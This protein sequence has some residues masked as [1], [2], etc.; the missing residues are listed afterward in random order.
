MVLFSL[1]IA[2]LIERTRQGPANWEVQPFAQ[3]WK[4]G[5]NRLNLSQEW[6]H[7]EA[8]GPLLWVVPAIILALLLE[9]QDS[10]LLLFIVNVAVLMIVLGCPQQR[11]ALREYL[12][13]ANRGDL[14]ACEGL[15]QE[16]DNSAL[17]QPNASVGQTL[18]W[19]NYRYYFAVAFWFILFGAPGALAYAMLRERSVEY[20]RI[21]HWV[22]FIPVRLAAFG[23]L[24]VGHFSRAMPAWLGG[25]FNWRE[26]SAT[27]LT[28]VA[29]K[30]EDVNAE[31]GD[32]TEEPCCLLNLAKRMMMLLLAALALATLLG[33][34]V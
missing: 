21:L 16:L 34:V 26:H 15:R 5:L 14:A 4:N 29:T 18:V 10:N 19:L 6:Q 17:D 9:W 20:A 1:L 23:Y 25:L 11:V 24:L 7:H 13:A 12:R 33:W 28:T 3:A 27:F 30:A 31:E 2:L 32:L 8:I 22:D